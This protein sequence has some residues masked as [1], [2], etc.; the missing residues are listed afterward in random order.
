MVIIDR[1]FCGPSD[2]ANGGYACGVAA[3]QLAGGG[4]VEVTLRSPPPL[5]RAIEVE[6]AGDRAVLRDGP[7]LVAEVVRAELALEAPAPVGFAEATAAAHGYP[8]AHAHPFPA[9]F[10]C[11]P[12][13]APGD[14]LRIFPGAVAGRSVAAAPWVPDGSVVDGDGRVRPEIVWAALDC[15]SWFGIGCFHAW[16]GRPLLGRLTAAIHDRPRAG[17]RCVCVGWKLGIDGRK[18][19]V[20]SAVFSEDG[21]L[22]A[23]AKATWITV[24]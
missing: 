14:G 18:H 13:R 9:C 21:A 19:H 5:G 11:G 23:I 1:R 6:L 4:P 15:P 22:R 10:V 20:G 7:Q 8:W 16:E 24:V 2:S 12:E 17:E 3:A